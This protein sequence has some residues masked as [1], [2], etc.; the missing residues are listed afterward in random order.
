MSDF[1]ALVPEGSGDFTA[2]ILDAP[3]AVAS[4]AGSDAAAYTQQAPPASEQRLLQPSAILSTPP[5]YMYY[6]G[7]YLS[8]SDFSA[9]FPGN[10]PGM[11]IE[12]AVG[13]T[14]YATLPW[15]GWARELLYVPT[16]SPVELYEVYPGGY[17]IA[18]NLGS[19][20]PGYYTIWYY[21]DGPGRH[22]SMI[23][24]NSGYSNQVIIDVYGS[25]SPSPQPKPDPQKE[26]AARGWPCYWHDGYCDCRV[27]PNPVAECEARGWPWVWQDGECKNMS[28][29]PNPVAECEKKQGCTWA[30]GECQ[31]FNPV[32]NPVDECES[33]PLCHYA[34]GQCYCT[35]GGGSE[36][37]NCE[38]NPLCDYVNGQCY[39]RGE[40]DSSGSMIDPVENPVS[41]CEGNGCRWVDG[42]CLCTGLGSSGS[43]GD[44]GDYSS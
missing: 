42:Q 10:Q 18:Y 8:W 7:K 37:Q 27:A 21:A 11:W 29:A 4:S 3:M 33:N 16:P 14:T 15:G 40:G 38:A 19:V 2:S 43:S 5:Q 34:D 9:T 25:L 28:P 20:Q 30:N 6:S 32:P 35:G 17:V 39:C 44:D 23:V 1:N 24:T 22:R 12:R 31:C 13:W 41:Q 36:K 26:C